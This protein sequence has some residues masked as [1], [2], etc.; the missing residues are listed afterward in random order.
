M[1]ITSVNNPSKKDYYTNL[2]QLVL[3]PSWCF[4]KVILFK[5]EEF[6]FLKG[7]DSFF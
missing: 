6:E 4:F 5:E 1:H 3:V 7:G 2:K